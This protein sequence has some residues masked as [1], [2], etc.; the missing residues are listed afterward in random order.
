MLPFSNRGLTAPRHH[1]LFKPVRLKN[2]NDYLVFQ[3]GVPTEC[4]TSEALNQVVIA[5]LHA[6]IPSKP[7]P[8]SCSG[9]E[10]RILHK[11]AR[12]SSFALQA[13]GPVDAGSIAHRRSSILVLHAFLDKKAHSD[14]GDA[15]ADASRWR[16]NGGTRRHG[17]DDD[18]GSA[19]N[20]RAGASRRCGGF[21]VEANTHFVPA[22]QVPGCAACPE[23]LAHADPGRPHD[24]Y[25]GRF[26]STLIE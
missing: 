4:P 6:A 14:D 18:K 22:P 10:V 1:R 20:D 7:S 25:A 23:R 8:Y 16:G 19:G 15:R 9:Q 2:S 5:V 11:D 3:A 26:R 13:S 24:R 12:H 17:S 21:G